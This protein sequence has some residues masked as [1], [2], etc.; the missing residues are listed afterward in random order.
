MELTAVTQQIGRIV[1]REKYEGEK[2]V[3]NTVENTQKKKH[4][5]QKFVLLLY[6][7]VVGRGKLF[8]EGW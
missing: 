5:T 8:K 3:Q 4:T 7:D 6:V 1:K 2:R